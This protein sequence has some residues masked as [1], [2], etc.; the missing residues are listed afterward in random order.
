MMLVKGAPVPYIFRPARKWFDSQ[1][2]RYQ[3]AL[4][5]EDR[6]P[7]PTGNKRKRLEEEMGYAMRRMEFEEQRGGNQWI[8]V[9]EAYVLGAMQGEVCQEFV[10]GGR[11]ERIHII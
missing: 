10:D 7:S 5:N 6:K 8:L 1:I 3:E 11:F 2:K 9:G 4:S